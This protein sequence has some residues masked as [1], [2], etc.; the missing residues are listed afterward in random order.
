M[1]Y[2]GEYADLR[3]DRFTSVG[4]YLEDDE[5]FEVL[6]PNKYLTNDMEENQI[7]NVYIYNDSEDRP[8]ATTETPKIE[9]NDFAFLKVKAISNFGAF[10]DWGLEKDL[11]VPFKEQTAKMVEEGVYLIR[12]YR[13][14]QTNRLVGSAR[15]NRYLENE[16]TD[17]EAGDEVDL[18]IAEIS[19]LGRKVI[20]NE[21]YSGLIFKDRL[22]RPLRNGERTKG[23]VEFIREDGKI[24]ISLV[25]IG[26]EKFDEFSEQLLTYLKENGGVSTV[27]DKSSPDLIRTELG[28]SKKSFKK[29]V[30][31]L[32][33]NKK[34]KLNDTSIELV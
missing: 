19:D 9:L 31:N 28:M 7:V 10:L 23:F 21:K 25:P 2:I 27:T 11:L 24:D 30:G 32:Y 6:L 34:I 20:V 13:D 26:L 14:E 1:V 4:A 5:G 29:A 18:F 15:I 22:V 33:K 17:L 16:V 3:I 8:V 12:L